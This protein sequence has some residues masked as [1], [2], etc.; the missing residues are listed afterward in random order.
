MI[1]GGDVTKA[2]DMRGGSFRRSFDLLRTVVRARPHRLEPGQRALRVAVMHSGPPAPGMNTAVRVALRVAMDNGHTVVGVRDGFGGLADGA[3]E[4]MNWMSVT[5]WVSEPGAELGT[6]ELVPNPEQLAAIAEQLT[7]NGIDGVLMI[8]G[9]VGY[10][11]A[12]RY[13]EHARAAGVH[14]V[15][16]VCIPASVSNDLPATDMSIGADSAL[17]SIVSDVDKI[18]QAAMGHQVD[19]VEVLGEQCGFLALLS[20]IATGAELVYLPEEG[21]S[22]QRLQEDLVH[23]QT[24]FAQGKR[25]GLVVRGGMSDSFYTTAFMEALFE[26]E[27]GGLFDVRSAILGQVQQGGRPSPFD[28]IHATRL[29]AAAVE[30]LVTQILGGEPVSAMIGMRKG[31]IEFSPLSKLPGRGD[32]GARARRSGWWMALRPIADVMARTE[33]APAAAEPVG[34][35]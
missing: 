13:D 16:F 26:H 10:A 23:L 8:G 14:P 29:A 25:R 19:V 32:A 11:A 28:R 30:H 31:R 34:D 4:E 6:D 5:G 7:A 9:W 20:G 27:S 15:P 22:L 12:A 24:G 2:M 33:S 1:A 21:M 17:N 18:K 3:F 35:A